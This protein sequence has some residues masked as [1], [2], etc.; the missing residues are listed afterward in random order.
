LRNLTASIRDRGKEIT[1]TGRGNGPIDAF[2]DALRKHSGIDLKVVDYR[3]H[4]VGAGSDANAVAYVEM[5]MTDGR[6]V[7]G[8]GKDSNIVTASLKA[9]ISATNR[10]AAGKVAPAAN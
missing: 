8:V 4:S 6:K 10:V 3:E 9:I 7:F 5:V 2:M 1:I